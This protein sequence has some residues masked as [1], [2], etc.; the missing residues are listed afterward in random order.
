M[1][2]SNTCRGNLHHP[3]RKQDFFL[4]GFG[5][6]IGW[7]SIE[8]GST[9]FAHPNPTTAQHQQC[10]QPWPELLYILQHVC[11]SN[12][13]IDFFRILNF[14]NLK[15][16]CN[17]NENTV[18]KIFF[19]IGI[20]WSA[21]KTQQRPSWSPLSG[22]DTSPCLD[23]ELVTALYQLCSS[24]TAVSMSVCWSFPLNSMCRLINQNPFHFFICMVNKKKT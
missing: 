17:L 22:P 24:S 13:N 14:I 11:L 23:R 20:L 12:R 7:T 3:W 6:T 19:P 16:R 21:K 18:Q 15:Y 1:F 2:L 8:K 5:R 4:G 9:W 10:T